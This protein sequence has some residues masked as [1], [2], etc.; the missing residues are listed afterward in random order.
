MW[1][2]EAPR[3]PTLVWID[4]L[5]DLGAGDEDHL[6]HLGVLPTR[7]VV[8]YPGAACGGASHVSQALAMSTSHGLVTSIP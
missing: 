7:D 4:D 5:E 1:P 2:E 3:K 6:A 8:P